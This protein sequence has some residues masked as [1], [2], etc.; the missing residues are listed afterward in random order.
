MGRRGPPKK[1]GSRHNAKFDTVVAPAAGEEAPLV[2]KAVPEPP[3]RLCDTASDAWRRL[4]PLALHLGKL[5]AADLPALELLC[6]TVAEF[7]AASEIAD[8][9]SE[10]Y[11][12]SEKGGIY[13]HPAVFRKQAA[14]KQMTALFAR[15][16]L[17]PMDRQTL[18]VT[19]AGASQAKKR[20]LPEFAASRAAPPTAKAKPRRGRK[21]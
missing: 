15:F 6:K 10:A 21:S 1:A 17:T 14:A 11:V 13:A 5:T 2:L 4:A 9:P 19:I 7:E 12:Y 16:G 3:D 18:G 8:N 20:G